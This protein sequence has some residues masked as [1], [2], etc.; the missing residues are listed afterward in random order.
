MKV[1]GDWGV[2]MV[3]DWGLELVENLGLE[4]VGD[5]GVKVVEMETGAGMKR[6]VAMAIS[7]RFGGTYTC[8]GKTQCQI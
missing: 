8:A 4:V 1:A 7:H 5:L 2:R 3:G 6:M